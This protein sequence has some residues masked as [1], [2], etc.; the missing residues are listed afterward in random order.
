MDPWSVNTLLFA[1]GGGIIGTVVGALFAFSFCGL[2]VL[3][4]CLIVLLGGSDWILLQ[5]GLGPIFGPHVGG[6][7]APV[8]AA[9][10][11]AMR[12]T[13]PGGTE[14]KVAKDI[15]SPLIGTSWDTILMGGV[16]G[17]VGHILFLLLVKIPVINMFDCVALA[18]AISA[19]LARFVFQKE[20]PWGNM[21]SIRKH[22]YLKTDNYNISWC[23][24]QSPPGR[25]FALGLGAGIFSVS[26]AMGA[27]EMLASLAA[28]NAVQA[29]KV[30]LFVTPLIMGWGVAVF[31]L[32][33]LTL[34]TG[35][36]QKFPLWHPQA[37]IAALAYM[38]FG[39]VAAGVVAGIGAS[40]L[41]ELLA[42]MFYNHGSTHIDP[43]GCT[44]ALGTFI[45]NVI[46]L[47][48]KL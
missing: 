3:F 17:L 4:G 48:S 25:L 8:A 39:S 43:P 11:A 45:V 18:V 23:G 12:G 41:Q 22:G 34:G 33:G 29:S 1:F 10:Y 7:A 40:F 31:S 6:F 38:H 46:H 26:L 16:F 32:F 9:C 27:Q 47:A 37:I 30:G 42:R 28:R 35:S 2:I 13:H 19:M 44:I 14:P 21:E 20:A 36:I 5:V 15:L 24:W